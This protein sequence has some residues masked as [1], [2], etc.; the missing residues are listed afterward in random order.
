MA[1][2]GEELEWWRAD[3]CSCYDPA[4][5]YDAQE[6]CTACD[7]GYVYRRQRGDETLRGIVTEVRREYLHADFGMLQVGD[8]LLQTIAPDFQPG[9]WDRIVLLARVEEQVTRCQVGVRDTLTNAGTVSEIVTV[10]DS[11]AEY[12]P[13]QDYDFDTETNAVEWIDGGSAPTGVYAVRF[14]QH[15]RYLYVGAPISGGRPTLLA[16]GLSPVFGQLV[17][18]RGGR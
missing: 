5:N 4:T 15:P 12:A 3:P 7:H 16:Q 11:T 17:R 9:L 1:Q 8:I 14:R 13:G 6:G 10:T 2:L 18:E